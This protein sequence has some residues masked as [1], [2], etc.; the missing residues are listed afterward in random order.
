[1][2]KLGM[3]FESAS[4]RSLVIGFGVI[5]AGAAIF[6]AI[7][8]FPATNLIRET[9]TAEGIITS[10]SNGECV[11]DTPDGIPKV[12][13]NC[14]LQQGSKVTVSFKEGMYEA[15]ISSQP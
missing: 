13:K 14:N 5:A 3:A 4:T 7:A 11:V 6:L 15:E 10:S 8:V 9:L 1:M 2:S 12:I